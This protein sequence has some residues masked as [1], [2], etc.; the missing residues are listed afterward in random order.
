[1]T[2]AHRVAAQPIANLQIG[3]TLPLKLPLWQHILVELSQ[4]LQSGRTIKSRYKQRLQSPSTCK[5]W[6][7]KSRSICPWLCSSWSH[8]R[9]INLH[10]TKNS[11]LSRPPRGKRLSS[12][13]N[14]AKVIKIKAL[15]LMLKEIPIIWWEYLKSLGTP[16]TISGSQKQAQSKA[17]L[18]RHFKLND[19]LMLQKTI[20]SLIIQNRRI[21]C[22]KPN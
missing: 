6:P 13:M 17:I 14:E 21:K 12:L 16:A 3:R 4:P 1:M 20:L 2:R 5:S 7:P 10:L 15:R 18:I 8:H 19:L 9:R 22:L 11:H